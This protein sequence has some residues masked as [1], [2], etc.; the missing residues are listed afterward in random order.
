M[1]AYNNLP[2]PNHAPPISPIDFS[3]VSWGPLPL[4]VSCS[5]SLSPPLPSLRIAPSKDHFFI[6]IPHQYVSDSGKHVLLFRPVNTVAETV[7][8]SPYRT[9]LSIPLPSPVPLSPLKTFFINFIPHQCVSDSSMHVLLVRLVNTATE[10]VYGWYRSLLELQIYCRWKWKRKPSVKWREKTR[11]C[12]RNRILLFT[13]VCRM[14]YKEL[15][16]WL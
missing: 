5:H 7:F 16:K 1:T 13:Q 11:L 2:P 4:L 8:D 3:S 9:P 10:T 14:I 15:I 12:D 6:V